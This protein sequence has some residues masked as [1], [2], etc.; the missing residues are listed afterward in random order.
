MYPFTA[1]VIDVQLENSFV[2]TLTDSGLETYT[3]RGAQHLMKVNETEVSS[4]KFFQV[5]IKISVI[6]MPTWMILFLFVFLDLPFFR[7]SDMSSW[8]SPIR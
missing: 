4:F 6:F 3:M 7:R 1:P 8:T 5:E 2:H